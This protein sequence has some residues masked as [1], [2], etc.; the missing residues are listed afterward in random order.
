[1]A[2][3][4]VRTLTPRAAPSSRARASSSAVLPVVITSSTRSA[5]RPPTRRGAPAANRVLRRAGATPPPPPGPVAFGLLAADHGRRIPPH[6]GQRGQLA[7]DDL[8]LVEAALRKPL[9]V[10][11]RGND[12]IDQVGIWQRVEGP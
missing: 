8:C 7:R 9:R 10:K 6:P 4:R 12:R 5:T 2:L 11:R 1:M 3:A